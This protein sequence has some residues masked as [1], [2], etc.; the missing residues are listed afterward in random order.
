MYL[1][2]CDWLPQGVSR[3]TTLTRGR[4]L[5]ESRIVSLVFSLCRD[6]ASARETQ[7]CD[8]TLAQ[9]HDT[10]GTAIWRATRPSARCDT[11]LYKQCARSLGSGCA[12]CAFDLV[13]TQC[14]ALSHC[15][16]SLSM[17]TVHGVFK[18]KH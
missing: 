7:R 8:M 2:E 14:T 16:G 6:T 4:V 11:A 12:P 15:F 17:N 3:R 13:L 5:E 18:K 9:R 1:L 10:T